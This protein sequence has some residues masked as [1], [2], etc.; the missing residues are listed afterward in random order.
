MN[1]N[2]TEEATIRNIRRLRWIGLS[3][4]D[5]KFGVP[6]SRDALFLPTRS[7]IAFHLEVHS[8]QY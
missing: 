4:D 8:N 3:E 5:V 6:S 7:E 2:S 1:L